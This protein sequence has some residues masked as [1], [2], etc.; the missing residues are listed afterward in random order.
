VSK[1]VISGYY[2]YGNLGDEAILA[3][4]VDSFRYFEPNIHITVLSGNPRWT[5]DFYRVNSIYRWNLFDITKAFKNADLFISGGGGLF[6]DVTGPGSSIYYGGLV[7]LAKKLKI[8]TMIFAQGIGP[9]NGIL[10][11]NIVKRSFNNLTA[12][13]VRDEASSEELVNLGID[14]NNINITADPALILS[15]ADRDVARAIIA[16]TSLDP[17]SP[18]IG[19]ALRPWQTWYERQLKSFSSI[20]TQLAYK[21]SIQLLLIPFQMSTDLWF[22]EELLRS[23]FCRPKSHIPPVAILKQT[24]N[25]YEMMSVIKEM[26]MVIGMRLHSIIMNLI[27]AIGIVYDPKIYNFSQIVGYP[28]LPSVTALQEVDVLTDTINT[29]WNNQNLYKRQLNSTIFSLKQSAWKNVEIAMQ[30]IEK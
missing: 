30:I 5:H 22:A 27:P 10:S 14:T 26:Q 29:V 8:P 4:M 18:V 16:H 20:I 19:I 15:S 9:L 12:I 13:T 17:D 23:I 3:S 7:T 21:Y 28:C 25:P 24:L 2:G 11:K 1:I 6:Q